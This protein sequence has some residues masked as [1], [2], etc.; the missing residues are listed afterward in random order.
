[1]DEF[2]YFS[3]LL[4]SSM[5]ERRSEALL[6][7]KDRRIGSARSYWSVRGIHSFPIV[8][9]SVI[10]YDFFFIFPALMATC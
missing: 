7:D 10:D 4:H 2:L 5:P 8:C 1:M 3:S 9:H 6:I